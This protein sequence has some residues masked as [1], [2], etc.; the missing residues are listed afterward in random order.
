MSVVFFGV[1][2]EKVAGPAFSGLVFLLLGVLRIGVSR[3]PRLRSILDRTSLSTRC[4][5]VLERLL[6]LS[7]TPTAPRAPPIGRFGTLQ[8]IPVPTEAYRRRRVTRL[9]ELP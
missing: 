5:E 1:S 2:V 4:F 7:P 8:P 9:N 3:R 6:S